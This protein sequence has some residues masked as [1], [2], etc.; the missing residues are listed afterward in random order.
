MPC[1]LQC[2]SAWHQVFE[3]IDD[4]SPP[5]VCMM[6][7]DRVEPLISVCKCC[8]RQAVHTELLQQIRTPKHIRKGLVSRQEIG[9]SVQVLV[10]V[11]LHVVNAMDKPGAQHSFGEEVCLQWLLLKVRHGRSRHSSN[12]HADRY[13]SSSPRWQVAFD[14]ATFCVC[15]SHLCTAI[16]AYPDN[17]TRKAQKVRYMW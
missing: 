5:P 12:I 10:H 8:P 2:C 13:F 11:S 17:T 9:E 15:Q 16:C 14:A 4:C 3:P 6:R 7:H 1:C